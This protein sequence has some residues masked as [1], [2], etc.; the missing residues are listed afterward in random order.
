MK[1]W[2]WDNNQ[3]LKIT[4][5]SFCIK[6]YHTVN[7]LGCL[8][9]SNMSGESMA[10]KC[11]LKINNKLKF[12]GRYKG[13][14]SYKL[15]RM[16]CNTFIQPHFDYGCSAWFPILSKALKHKFQTAQNKCVRFCLNWGPLHHIGSDEFKTIWIAYI[17]AK[18]FENRRTHSVWVIHTDFFL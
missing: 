5:G 1:G 8:L 12:L 13:V 15:R 10:K 7:Y 14:L 6:Q 17:W 11:L 18:D 16:L 3:E 9:D 2:K 4:R